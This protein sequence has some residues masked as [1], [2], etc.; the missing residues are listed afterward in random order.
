MVGLIIAERDEAKN[1][2]K[3]LKAKILEFNGIRYYVGSINDKQV[4]MCF[5]GM[6]KANAASAAM[7]MI[8]NFNVKLIF[9]IGLCGSC[10]QGIAPGSV[11]VADNIQYYDVD[12]T[13]LDYPLNQIPGEL[14]KFSV[15]QNY[16]DFLKSINIGSIVG[17][18]ATG[19]TFVTIANIEA[20]PTLAQKEIVGFEMEACA[21]AQICY[22]TKTDFA[23]VKIVSDNLLFDSDSKKLYRDNLKDLPKQIESIAKKVLEYYSK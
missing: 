14:V 7:N 15:K 13:S 19:D 17:T 12:L 4:V 5:S 18:I 11:L 3:S 10:K 16:V 23:C 22:K 20:F 6:G 9:N 21:I 8:T 2:I 1:L